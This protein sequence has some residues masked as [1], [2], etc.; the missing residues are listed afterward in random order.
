MAGKKDTWNTH[1]VTRA[2][3]RAARE[4]VRKACYVILGEAKQQVPL[5]EGTLKS[6]GIVL[7]A[8]GGIP[9]GLISFGGGTGTGHPIVP[10]AVRWHENTANFQRGRKRYY[11]RDPVNS[12]AKKVLN[13]ALAQELGKVLRR[14]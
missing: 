7:M 4:A 5:D 2:T 6:S 9:E 11:L 10:Y 1:K 13:K 14:P 8:P 3:I 12:L